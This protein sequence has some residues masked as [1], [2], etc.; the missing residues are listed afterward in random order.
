MNLVM[1]LGKSQNSELYFYWRLKPS[2][3]FVNLN[4]LPV[5]TKFPIYF[6]CTFLYNKMF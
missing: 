6:F 1:T 4:F 2:T 3:V 5:I